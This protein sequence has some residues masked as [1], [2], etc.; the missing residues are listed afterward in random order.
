MIL[1]QNDSIVIKD[2]A[3]IQIIINDITYNKEL[4]KT[5]KES[6]KNK[7]NTITLNSGEWKKHN[8]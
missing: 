3:S 7:I 1:F 2:N 5:N 4:K 8:E 6:F